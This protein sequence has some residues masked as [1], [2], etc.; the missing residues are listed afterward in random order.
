MAGVVIDIIDRPVDDVN[1]FIEIEV[2]LTSRAHRTKMANVSLPITKYI[3]QYIQS[4]ENVFTNIS[5]N[6]AYKCC[7]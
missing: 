6:E 2:K 3:D 1:T 5:R 4:A 7:L